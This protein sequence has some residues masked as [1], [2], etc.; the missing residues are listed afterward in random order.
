M[1]LTDYITSYLGELKTDL[2]VSASAIEFI[3][4]ETIS[5]YG[6]TT[7]ALMTDTAKMYT[8]AKMETWKRLMIDQS[9]SFDF[10]ADGGDYK[11]SQIMKFLQDNYSDALYDASEYMSD[12]VIDVQQKNITTGSY[13]EEFEP[14][15]YTYW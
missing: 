4:N 13:Y 8:L 2:D 1:A 5:D 6:V 10:K 15:L 12:Y 11:T 9:A 7:E 14:R 3:V